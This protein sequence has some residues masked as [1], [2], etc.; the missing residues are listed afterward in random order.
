MNRRKMMVSVALA[1]LTSLAVMDAATA[2]RPRARSAARAAAVTSTPEERENYQD[3]RSDRQDSRQERW[4]NASPNQKAVTYNVA[5]TRHQQNVTRQ[6]AG[7]AAI[8]KRR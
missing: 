5:K 4:N 3:N 7:A 8:S 2:L 6:A 1:T